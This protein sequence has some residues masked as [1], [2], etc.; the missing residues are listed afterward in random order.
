MQK[1]LHVTA[2]GEC[3][4]AAWTQLHSVNACSDLQTM[5]ALTSSKV[6]RMDFGL[7]GRLMMSDLPLRP[8]VCLDRTA[9]GTYL[10]TDAWLGRRMTSDSCK[11]GGQHAYL[12]LI[13]RICSP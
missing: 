13:E 3:R 5:S 8:A 7:P 2:D 1:C 12:R 11:S 9:V 6:S 4:H 10:Q